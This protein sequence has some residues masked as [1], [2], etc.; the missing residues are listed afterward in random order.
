MRW[1]AGADA[2]ETFEKKAKELLEYA[3]PRRKLSSSLGHADA[4]E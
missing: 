3:G 2:V 1:P 4:G